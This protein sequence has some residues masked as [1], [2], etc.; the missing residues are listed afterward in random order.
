MNKIDIAGVLI[1]NIS[2]QDAVRKIDEFVASG[3]PHYVATPYSE[4][5]VFAQQDEQYK[6]ILNNADLALPDGIGILWA[7]KYLS[8]KTKVPFV[9]FVKLIYTLSSILFNPRLIRSVIHEQ[10]TGSQLIW[11]IARL[12][13][14]RNYSMALVGGSNAVAAQTAYEL[15]KKYP[16]LNI[17]L[18][19]SGAVPFDQNLV[20]DINDSSSDILLIAYSPPKQEKWIAENLQKLNVKVAMGLGGTFDYISGKRLK[21][22]KLFQFFGLEWLWRL[23]T[24]SWRIKRMWNAVPVFI[25][26]VYK[27]K[28]NR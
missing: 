12:A 13:A 1:D 22:P 23:I 9:K 28:V 19:I 17:K 15:K 4:L 5:I 26:K 21:A 10:V 24:Q 27:Y 16:G 11:D 3:K 18:A 2:K 7:A 25:W 6:K 20:N 8:L 14:D